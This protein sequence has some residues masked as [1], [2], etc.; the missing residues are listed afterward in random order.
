MRFR[1]LCLLSLIT[2]FVCAAGICGEPGKPTDFGKI[3]NELLSRYVN[4]HSLID[5]KAWK[6]QPEDIDKLERLIKSFEKARVDLKSKDAST[7]ALLINAYNAL[8]IHK[9]LKNYPVDSVQ[10]IPKFF[11]RKDCKISG[12][13]FSLNDIETMIRQ[14]EDGRTHSALSGGCKSAPPMNTES[15]TAE[16][17]G[18]QLNAQMQAWLS[19][20][21]LNEFDCSDKKIS[22]SKIFL[23]YR[24]D[25]GNDDQS[26]IELLN[27]F[28]P[29]GEWRKKIKSG[30]CHLDF[31]EFDGSLNDASAN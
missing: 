19:D 25:F 18:N 2:V 17:L 13:N 9:I 31:M 4:E 14:F 12:E 10:S 26:I 23:W 15:F 6:S 16:R 29:S 8:V 11:T 7:L 21:H 3:W 20:Q 28:G 30:D 1:V 27:K 5:Y 22:I 24:R